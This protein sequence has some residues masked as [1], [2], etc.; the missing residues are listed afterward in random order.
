ME[1][2]EPKLFL[3]DEEECKGGLLGDAGR[4][5]AGADRTAGPFEETGPACPGSRDAIDGG[6]GCSSGVPFAYINLLK[7]FSWV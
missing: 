6:G 2:W 5:E 4:C 7:I 1:L 3:C